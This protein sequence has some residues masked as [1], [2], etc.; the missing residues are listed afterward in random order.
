MTLARLLQMQRAEVSVY[1][2]DTDRHARI[3]GSAL[4]LHT[5]SGLAALGA[6]GLMDAFWANHRPELDRLRLMSHRQTI[7]K[8]VLRHVNK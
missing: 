3:T 2:R 1:E 8:V 4:D 5:D 6:A 7:G